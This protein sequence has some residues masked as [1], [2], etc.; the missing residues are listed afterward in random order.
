MDQKSNQ[1][2]ELVSNI[3]SLRAAQQEFENVEIGLREKN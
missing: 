2:L 3:E 1:I